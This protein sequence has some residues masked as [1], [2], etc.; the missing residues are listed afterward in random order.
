MSDFLNFITT[1]FGAFWDFFN[2]EF[3]LLG[4]SVFQVLM[5][6]LFIH[7]GI[8]LIV[9]LLRGDEGSGSH[10]NNTES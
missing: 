6:A 8:K 4:M 5:A 7:L 9:Q 2:I 1:L 3:P 10:R